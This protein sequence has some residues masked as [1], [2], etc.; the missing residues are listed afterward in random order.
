[1]SSPDCPRPLAAEMAVW[2]D[3][4]IDALLEDTEPRLAH[5]NDQRPEEGEGTDAA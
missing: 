1:M 3:D 5:E 4:E 2:N